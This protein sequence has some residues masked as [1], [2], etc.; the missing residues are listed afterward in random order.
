MYYMYE[1]VS[2]CHEQLGGNRQVIQM[3]ALLRGRFRN[4]YERTGRSL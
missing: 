3:W 4:K 2:Y 1:S